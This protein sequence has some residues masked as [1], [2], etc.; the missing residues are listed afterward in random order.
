M[1]I[2]EVASILEEFAPLLYQESYDNS[3]LTIGNS[4]NNI[5]S[6]L[7][8]VDVTEEVIDEAINK[9]ANLIIAHHPIIFKGIKSITGKSYVE[10]IVAKAI[11]NDIAVY[12]AHTN[13]DGVWGG[14]NTKLGEKLGLLNIKIL[15][16]KKGELRKLVT[17]VPD[18]H[19][20]RVR[21]AIFD[22]GAGNIGS[23]DQ[24][25]FN[26]H[27]NGS[28]RAS[29]N[30]NPYKGEKGKLH[31]EKEIRIETIFPKYLE[32]SIVNALLSTH[33]Y[34]EVAYDIYPLD[35]EFI[36]AGMGAIGELPE[37]EEEE[38]FLADL[39]KMFNLKCIRHSSLLGKK[40]KRIAVC[41]GTGSFLLKNAISSGAD[42]FLTADIK[43]HE[44]FDADK[45]ILLVDIGH[46]ES[47]QVIK[48]IFYELLTKKN[49]NFAVHF[50][51]IISNPVNYY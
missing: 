45:K 6:V 4:N 15:S 36:K 51:G 9:K 11:K 18:E 27:G 46:Y 29:E 20:N 42:A 8:T 50:S 25:S 33:P 40:V 44:Y 22:A 39:K 34:E 28:F 3:G 31:F 47:E 32:R 10:R 37:N 17:F 24:C 41:G 49:L 30:S 7:L 43:Y 48:D 21:K 38:V 13:M 2:K 14:V 35:N 26:L 5:S 12:A 19:S 16:P 1:T 23:Y